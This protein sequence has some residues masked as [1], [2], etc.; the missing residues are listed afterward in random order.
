MKQH[1]PHLVSNTVAAQSMAVAFG[2]VVL[3]GM[4]G[5]AEAQTPPA[6]PA[7]AAAP[8]VPPAEPAP[9]AP[10][11][12]TPVAATPP[13]SV[14]DHDNV[15]GLWGVEARSLGTFKRTQGEDVDC[16]NPCTTTLNALSV[17]RWMNPH[18]AYS[19]GLAVGVG[20]GSRRNGEATETFDTYLGVGPTLGASF[21]LA[22]FKHVAVSLSPQLDI[23]YFMPSGKGAKS[24]LANLRGMVEAEVHLGMIGLPT[25]SVG[26]SSGL[27]ASLLTVSQDEKTPSPMAVASRWSLGVTGPTSLWD[28]VTNATLR[29]YF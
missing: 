14:N 10:I 6:A 9:V 23:V 25:A 16:G 8:A 28:L 5:R 24:F 27:V 3:G 21:L 18:Y 2:L 26:L 7:P 15:V 19:V 13:S 1:K 17:R 29:Y 20:G 12:A 22:N 11:I 4:A